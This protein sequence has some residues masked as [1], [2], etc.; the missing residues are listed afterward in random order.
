MKLIQSIAAALLG[1]ALMVTLP[2][3]EEQG[4]FEEAGEETDE[5][6]EDAGD[7]IDDAGDGR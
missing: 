4:P 3:C 2:A 7:A 1:S 6:F 5:A